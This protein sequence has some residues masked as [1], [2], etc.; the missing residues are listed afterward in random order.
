M[1]WIY[2]DEELPEIHIREIVSQEE[3]LRENPTLVTFTEEEIY[4]DLLN[5]FKNRVQTANGYLELHR[6][7]TKPRDMFE[8]YYRYAVFHVHAQRKRYDVAATNSRIF[9]ALDSLRRNPNYNTREKIRAELQEPFES[10]GEEAEGIPAPTGKRLRIRL[11]TL[12]ESVRLETDIEKYLIVA[13]EF[14]KARSVE[15]MYLTEQIQATDER[16]IVVEKPVEVG[17]TS[18]EMTDKERFQRFTEGLVPTFEYILQQVRE[19]RVND[20]HSLRILFQMYGRD[21]DNIGPENYKRLA[22]IL[23]SIESEEGES[24]GAEKKEKKPWHFDTVSYVEI[25]ALFWKSMLSRLTLG[26]QAPLYS[27]T[28]S[29]AIAQ[30]LARPIK[31]DMYVPIV[32]QLEKLEKGGLKLEDFVQDIQL[33]RQ[34]YE[35]K[36][37]LDF[38]ENVGRLQK[39]EIE[40][41]E[42]RI[43]SIEEMFQRTV[44]PEEAE[45]MFGTGPFLKEYQEKEEI[46]QGR[47][48]ML[49]DIDIVREEEAPI[50]EAFIEMDPEEVEAEEPE[51][52]LAMAL[53]KCEDSPLIDILK[54]IRPCLTELQN[55]TKMP[56]NPQEFLRILMYRAPPIIDIGVAMTNLDNTIHPDI[57]QTIR[58]KS[59]EEATE[60][61]T[62]EQERSLRNTYQKALKELKKQRSKIFF[63]FISYWVLHIQ[64]MILDELFVLD[65]FKESPQ[66]IELKGIG[67]PI[68]EGRSARKGVLHYFATILR[69]EGHDI[70][71]IQEVIDE[72]SKKELEA[73]ITEGFDYFTHEIEAMKEQA[74]RSTF[75]YER[76][77]G[78][79]EAAAALNTIEKLRKEKV[80]RPQDL[81][82]P[83]IK[84]IRLLPSI[85]RNTKERHK[86][87]LGCCYSQLNSRYPEKEA[88]PNRMNASRNYFARERFGKKGRPSLLYYGPPTAPTEWKEKEAE[89]QAGFSSMEAEPEEEWRDLVRPS[90]ILSAH[91]KQALNPDNLEEFVQLQNEA[92]RYLNALYRTINKP[93]GD[94]LW[95]NIGGLSR[96]ELVSL[97]RQISYD[98]YQYSMTRVDTYPD[99]VP[100]LEAGI[101]YTKEALERLDI[102]KIPEK[103][104]GVL[105]VLLQYILA[106]TLCYPGDVKPQG[107]RI[108]IE[109][110]MVR[111]GFIEDLAN[112]MANQ[113]RMHIE[114]RIMP[115]IEEIE[116]RI[117]KIREK[118][119]MEKLQKY[120]KN[121]E[122]NKL[123]NQAKKQGIKIDMETYEI[124]TPATNRRAEDELADIEGAREFEMP[125]QDP[126]EMNDDAFGDW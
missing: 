31:M 77:P 58:E 55:L 18:E 106:R 57:I 107:S 35:H 62:S 86:H 123:I 73:Q 72:Y 28:I 100:L 74:A 46:V 105:K 63:L 8:N 88:I 120:E 27:E 80:F 32:E 17:E 89:G 118:G 49:E 122:L 13:G 84:T 90:A 30:V 47:D 66:I 19:D 41:L 82:A 6:E 20:L 61:L 76:T 92:K 21:L 15:E 116:K 10:A 11:A 112:H 91:A 85:L 102:A 2:L 121:P 125:T 7:I 70:P 50:A 65:N 14:W 40:K 45:E 108:I 68:E 119:K 96:L 97:I 1:S 39:S 67:Y 12:D 60:M 79:E 37:L 52:M 53:E 95:R 51:D 110:R 38:Q 124:E 69:E 56:W 93:M 3:L 22:H 115:T 59:F 101:R 43:K 36:L 94:E 81:L 117:S 98:L 29:S 24:E 83:Y 71:G 109:N 64:G 4:N 16:Q 99:E 54:E 126:D 111:A 104:H 44:D 26:R 114:G 25:H 34:F 87:I 113:L 78:S 33:L 23:G 42:E 9:E 5:L 103:D 75:V 48:E